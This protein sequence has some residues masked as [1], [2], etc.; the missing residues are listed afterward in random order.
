[1]NDSNASHNTGYINRRKPTLSHRIEYAAT[2]LVV[3][4]LR[5]LGWRTASSIGG[6]L[7]R[8]AYWPLGIRRGVTTRQIAAAFPEKPPDE[9]KR[10]AMAS[11]DSLGRTSIETAILPGTKA[12]EILSR[13]ERVD[14]WEHVERTLAEGRGLIIVTG[15]IGNWE[16]GGAYMAARGIAFDAVARGMANPIFEKWV[17]RTR[18]DIGMEVIHDQDAVRRT[19]RSLRANRAVAFVSDHD[20]LSLAST[21]VPFFG[22]PARTPR[23]PGVFA[24][25]FEAP[26]LF[27]VCIRMPS[28]RYV[29]FVEPIEIAPSG[30]READVDAIMLR[31]TELLEEKVREY[32]EQ[33]FWQHRRWRRQPPDTPP[34]LREP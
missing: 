28:G 8:L 27:M 16:I 17:N 3:A 33:Y 10:I 11:Y 22:R 24:L 13:I 6:R 19:P 32:P 25:R 23:G 9:V 21:Y 26:I 18:S 12:S 4:A 20:A 14:G 2:R 29:I 7:A 34:H 1:M 15:H 30:N 5:L 31:F